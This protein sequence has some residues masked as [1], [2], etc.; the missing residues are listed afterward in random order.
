MRRLIIC[1]AGAMAVLTTAAAPASAQVQ[2]REQAAH[3]D[4]EDKVHHPG[5]HPEEGGI[6]VSLPEPS[7]ACPNN[8]GTLPPA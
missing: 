2:P 6:V 7:E 1:A 5:F 8:V 3:C 4:G